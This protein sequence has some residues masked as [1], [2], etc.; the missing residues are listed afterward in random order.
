MI[1][2]HL[3]TLSLVSPGAL[4]RNRWLPYVLLVCLALPLLLFRLD[5]VPAMWFDEGYKANAARTLA[6]YGVYG[7]SN[8]FGVIPF[9]AATT[10]GPADT[11]MM[12]VSFRVLGPGPGNLRLGIL[13]FTLLAI[14]GLYHLAALM[15]G[16]RTA[17]LSVLLVLAFPPL[18]RTSFLLLGRQVMGEVPALALIVWGVWMWFHSWRSASS[19]AWGLT[20]GILVALGLLSKTQIAISLLPALSAI[21]LLALVWRTVPWPKVIVP[22]VAALVAIAG[23][24]ATEAFLCTGPTCS[25]NATFFAT[26]LPTLLFTDVY[27]ATINRGGMAA[28]VTM[29]LAAG[30]TAFRLYRVGRA[31]RQWSAGEWAQAA[32]A[33][34]ITF[35]AAWFLIFSIGW[36]RYAFA[37]WIVAALLL[38]E[39]LA[40]ALRRVAAGLAGA[41]HRTLARAV[42]PVASVI[43]AAAIVSATAQ[44]LLAA[45]ASDPMQA[46]AAYIDQTLAADAVIETWEWELG[47]ST[48]HRA[49]SYP[50]GIYV[51]RVVQRQFHGIS[52]VA[53]DHDFLAHDP[54]YLVVGPFAKY[55]GIYPALKISQHFIL[56][57][58]EGPYDLYARAR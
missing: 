1:W 8:A 27:G 40:R 3:K 11:L 41:N 28:A 35:Y 15:F 52:A 44:P 24:K 9:D 56:Q 20:G 18:E 4:R 45:P 34:W 5:R 49:Y 12:A 50:D 33:I 42:E 25:A 26:A 22:M 6:E 29:V 46:M 53:L 14:L 48:Q 7:T 21:T 23:W 36:T 58:S 10:N 30:I 51:M 54:D 32:L 57:H 17:F 55:T 38:G 37:G 47:V 2:S 19:L 16:R 39:P 43:L 13:P 31:H